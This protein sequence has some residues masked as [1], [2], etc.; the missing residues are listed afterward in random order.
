MIYRGHAANTAA[1]STRAVIHCIPPS[2]CRCEAEANPAPLS[3]SWTVDGQPASG[4]QSDF[5]TIT[6][7]SLAY[8][9]SV[10]KCEVRNEIGK[11]EDSATIRVRCKYPV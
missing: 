8:H 4:F 3:Y 11:S 10:V 2:C 6:N 9:N 1:S 7:I 5:F